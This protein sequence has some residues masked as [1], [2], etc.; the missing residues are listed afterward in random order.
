[1]QQ[2]PS[3]P[4][5]YRPPPQPG[6]L[7]PPAHGM[8]R[9]KKPMGS[10]GRSLIVVG[11]ILVGCFVAGAVGAVRKKLGASPAPSAAPDLAK[12]KKNAVETSPAK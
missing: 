10:L 9:S 6:Y 12:A 4:G 11:I 3:D 7:P 1:M 2:P 5:A 8:P